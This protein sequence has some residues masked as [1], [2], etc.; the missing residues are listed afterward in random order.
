MFTE[1]EFHVCTGP[2]SVAQASPICRRSE[3]QMRAALCNHGRED[4]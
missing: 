1:P 2:V 4:F 3:P